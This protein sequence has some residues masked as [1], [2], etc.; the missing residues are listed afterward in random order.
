MEKPAYDLIVVGAGPAGSACAITA[1]R[2]GAKVLL[3][4]QDRFPRHKVCG[5]FVSP[6]SLQLLKW[7]LDGEHLQAQPEISRARIFSGTT[8]T[9]LPISPPGRSI[10]RFDLDAALL[11][12]ARQA[13]VWARENLTVR[14]S[15]PGATFQ[16]RSA[17]D[18]FFA[19]AVVNASGRWSQLTQPSPPMNNNWIGIKGHFCEASPFPSADLYFFSQGY[20]G[21]QPVSANVVN[22]CAMVR[23]KAARSLEEVFSR[24]QE[25]QRRSRDW[26]PLFTAITTSGL[27]FRLPQ[28]QRNGMLLAG[29]AAAFIDPFAGDGISLALQSGTLAAECLVPFFQAR[30][31][32]QQAGQNYH[33]AYMNRFTSAFRNAARIRMLVSM[34]SPIRSMLARLPAMKSF[35]RALVSST[36]AKPSDHRM[37]ASPGDFVGRTG[38]NLK[39]P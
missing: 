37:I 39:T 26:E 28:T 19:R 21:V 29:D 13:G 8:Q 35:A 9:T 23:A 34:P 3:L 32:L 31:S 14:E 17:E 6:E 16:V 22:V 36:R 25:L 4:E 30:Y 27:H 20:C 7:L 15:R 18:T 2:A 1:A 10:P 5:E 12:A 24:Q 33:A 38:R 11:K